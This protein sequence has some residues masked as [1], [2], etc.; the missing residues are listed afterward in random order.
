M[1][2]H[3][4]VDTVEELRLEG[5]AQ[6]RQHGLAHALE[7]LVIVL[8]APAGKAQ[9][10]AHGGDVLRADVAGHDDDRVLEVHVPSLCVGD[11]AVLQDLQ[12]DVP[13]VLVGLFDLVEEHHAV[14][15]AAHLFGQLAA[16]VIADVARGRADQ[17][18]HRVPL[19]ILGHI[20]ADHGVLVAEHGLC[21]RLA[22]LGLAHARGAEEQE[23]T[24]GALGVLDADPAAAD[25]AGH[26]AHGLILA[27]H[28][29]VQRLLQM[30]QPLALI[31]GQPRDGNTRPAGDHGGDVLLGDAAVRL[32]ELLA[33]GIALPLGLVA[34]VRLDVAQLRGLFIVLRRN[35][36]G[37]LAVE[38]RDLFLDRLELRRG[39]LRFHAHAGGR[40]V[41]Q[42]DG[43]VGQET[44]VDIAA[45]KLYGRLQRT[46]GDGQLVVRLVALAQPLEDLQR[47]LAGRLADL[48]R[49][50]AAL[51]RG[52][53]F[54]ILAVLGQ[55]GR[56]DHADLAAAQSG[57]DDVG[58][59]H[60]ALGAARAD[61]V[62]QLIDEEDHV[63]GLLHLVEQALDALFKLAAVFGPRDHAAQVQRQQAF[64]H[65]L[66]RHVGQDDLL[67]KSLGNGRLADAR[68]ADEDGVILGAAGEDLDRAGDLLVT[69][70]HRVQLALARHFG[71]IAR[72]FGKALAAAF[73]FIFSCH[74]TTFSR[75]CTRRFIHLAHHTAA[76]LLEINARRR[77]Q[78]HG[79][80]A[81]VAQ[82]SQQQMLRFDPL[83]VE[84]HRLCHGH[85]NSAAGAGA[86]PLGGIGA[87]DAA[88]RGA[89]DQIA[90]HVLGQAR[91]LQ[92]AAGNAAVLAQQRQQQVLAADIAVSQ[93]T[94]CLLCQAQHIL[95]L[96]AELFLT[97]LVSLPSKSRIGQSSNFLSSSRSFAARS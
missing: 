21:Q 46:V 68:L 71:Q 73:A 27:D 44:V 13:H 78:A 65:Q 95:R 22:Q 43:L 4:L 2:D 40:L 94:G 93:L 81:A 19:H 56:A 54:N 9:F 57:L 24:D 49:L 80:V 90:H 42:V 15:L 64:V 28:A 35:G 7:A 29:L 87:H 74:R 37:L 10:V 53:L 20:D 26:R 6:L 11:D 91:L 76:Q 77:Q 45:G 69:S 84:A 16:L 41:H 36:R 83:A 70:D 66:L 89:H 32:G 48:D 58:G 23:R 1:E 14:G 3:C 75:R 60:G 39:R 82:Q 79:H 33:P 30:Q 92:R 12:Q 97:H 18:R 55:C 34:V 17:T 38:R 5:A 88:A 25:R 62:V 52:V 59:V 61:D 86:E 47:L 85:F 63:A 96:R 67:G 51:Q 72:E 8:R 50:E 31:L